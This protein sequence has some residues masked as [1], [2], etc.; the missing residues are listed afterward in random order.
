MD[1]ELLLCFPTNNSFRLSKHSLKL[2]I[3][4]EKL[5]GNLSEKNLKY[6]LAIYYG[7]LITSVILPIIF[8]IIGYFL[9]GKIYFNSTLLVFLLIFIWSLF[10]VE[11]FKKRMV[12]ELKSE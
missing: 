9:N 12:T 2:Q 11:Y 6:A 3:M 1:W 8:L 7:L 10:N 4:F 5:Y